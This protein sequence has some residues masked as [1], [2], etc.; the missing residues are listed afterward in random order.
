M[1]IKM[2]PISNAAPE[3]RIRPATPEDAR[4][5]IELVNAAFAVED[6]LEGTRT[7]PERLA[8][9]MQK[10]TILLA[11]DERGELAAS[12]YVE[13][14]GSRGYMGMLAVD[15]ARQ[16]RGLAG[17]LLR[18][19]EDHMR[20]AGCEA[21]DITVLSLRPELLPIYRRFGFVE[22]GTEEFAYGRVFREPMDCHCI[23]MSKPL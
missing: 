11:E 22:N 21:V 16:G 13:I 5:I 14:R 1:R 15:P 12:V 18:A 17:L 8:V 23:K 4:R 9:N 7:D 2:T 19:A 6:F 20:A 10:G 3:F